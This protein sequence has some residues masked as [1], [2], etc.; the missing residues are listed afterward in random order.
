VFL[1][2]LFLALAASVCHAGED[3][4]FATPE[5]YCTLQSVG[6]IAWG[7]SAISFDNVEIDPEDPEARY[8]LRFNP[9]PGTTSELFVTEGNNG[10]WQDFQFTGRK[11]G[12]AVIDV[13]A[14]QFPVK[15]NEE[16]E[17]ELLDDDGNL[18]DSVILY[19]LVK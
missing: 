19:I 16:V 15:G 13:Y 18:L 4:E 1:S 6:W 7:N 10:A 17:I 12:D 14:Y 11:D 8:T 5:V 3:E 2:V 9:K